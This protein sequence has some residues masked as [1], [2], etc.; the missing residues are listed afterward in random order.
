[1]IT[2]CGGGWGSE[3][4]AGFLQ[5]RFNLSPYY[6]LFMSRQ[7]VVHT[8]RAVFT[9]TNAFEHQS[10]G[11]SDALVPRSLPPGSTE[12]ILKRFANQC[13]PSSVGTHHTIGSALCG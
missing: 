11:I 7:D 8:T 1:M 5:F 3:N 13:Q 10:A 12:P 9:D 6:F 2:S 4:K